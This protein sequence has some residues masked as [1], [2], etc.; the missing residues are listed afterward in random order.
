[1][2]VDIETMTEEERDRLRLA[3]RVYMVRITMIFL[4]LAS[5]ISIFCE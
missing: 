4:I 5:V 1:M 2:S 3:G